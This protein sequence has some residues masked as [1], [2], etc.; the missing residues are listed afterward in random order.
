MWITGFSVSPDGQSLELRGRALDAAAVPDY[1]A[2]L[3]AE[4]VF[5]GRQ[6]GQLSLSAVLPEGAAEGAA[7]ITEFT[8]R[9]GAGAEGAR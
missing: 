7:P 6:F 1:L 2:H 8:L 3:N 9:S 4:P 5:R